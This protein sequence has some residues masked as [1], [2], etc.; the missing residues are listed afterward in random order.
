MIGASEAVSNVLLGLRNTID[1]DL[2]SQLDDKYK[3]KAER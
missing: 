1:R 3:G 2:P